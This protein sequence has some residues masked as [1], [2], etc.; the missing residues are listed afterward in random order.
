[1]TDQNLAEDHAIFSLLLLFSSAN[2][3]LLAQ[4]HQWLRYVREHPPSLQEQ[5][6]DLVRQAQLKQLARLADERWAS[7]PSY[8]DAPRQPQEQQ[9]HPATKTTGDTS[10]MPASPATATAFHNAVETPGRGE[11][12]KEATRPVKKDG[13]QNSRDEQSTVS[14]AKNPWAA[15]DRSGPSEKWQ[16]ESWT[17]SASR[18]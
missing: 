8:L 13:A 14:G 11:V 10:E 17:P 1:M 15:S 6:G 18:R 4:W 2:R 9:P 3:C 5:Q 7:K 16:P 12:E